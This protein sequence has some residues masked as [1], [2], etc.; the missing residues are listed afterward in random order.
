[1]LHSQQDSARHKAVN[2]IL[3]ANPLPVFFWIY[4]VMHKW[5]NTQI[6]L[7]RMEENSTAHILR[8]GVFLIA[9]LIALLINYYLMSQ[10]FNENTE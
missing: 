8:H 9:S 2:G 5:P 6:K 10:Q 4:A 1:M 3:H 7:V